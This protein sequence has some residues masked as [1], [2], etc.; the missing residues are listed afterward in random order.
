MKTNHDYWNKTRDW[1]LRY[2]INSEAA[3]I[4]ALSSGNIAKCE[5]LTGR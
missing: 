4:L 5:Y 1:K 3:K 2:D